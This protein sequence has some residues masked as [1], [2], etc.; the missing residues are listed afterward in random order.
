MRDP[1]DRVL[2]AAVELHDAREVE[3]R[4]TRELRGRYCAAADVRLGSACWATEDL[5]PP[6][7]CESCKGGLELAQQ[8]R[9]ARAARRAA[10]GKLE[11]V[12]AALDKTIYGVA[13][14]AA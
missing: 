5:S 11:R 1:R 6:D 2:S 3:R 10:I 14:R 13:A 4:L 7:Y 12:M 9:V 8:R